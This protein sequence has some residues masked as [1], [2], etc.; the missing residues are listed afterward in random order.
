[1][2]LQS[3]TQKIPVEKF[4][5]DLRQVC[6]RFDIRQ[7][8]AQAWIDGAISLDERAGIEIVNVA[9]SVQ[10][11]LRTASDI[12]RDSGENYFLIMQHSGNAL[13]SQNDGS[14]MLSPGDMILIDS[15][16][17]SEFTFFGTQNRQISIHLPREEMHS[18]FGYD[19]VK[20]GLAVPRSN[21][22]NIALQGII[23]SIFSKPDLSPPTKTCLREA[24]MGIVG[25]ILYERSGR[26]DFSGVQSEIY[27]TR[28]LSQARAYIDANYR[29]PE[30]SFQSM[31]DDLGTSLRQIQRAFSS[32][33]PGLTPSKYL[34][35]K[36]LEHARHGL[37]ERRRGK[38]DDHI[39]A[40]AYEAGFSDLSYFYRCFRKSFGKTPRAYLEA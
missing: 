15:A 3:E 32:S 23:G 31:A 27:G 8:H 5:A 2:N 39:S 38:R 30:L 34:L 22:S 16:I 37:D 4:V 21:P 28:A 20:G 33:D 17:P 1:M 25:A 13:M 19:L 10:Q 14:F 18:R 12:R 24:L 26:E 7:D 36:R 29:N 11:I 9:T 35:V 40:I 6:G